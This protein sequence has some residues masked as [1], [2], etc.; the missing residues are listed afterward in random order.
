MRIVKGQLFIIWTLT[1]HSNA[2]VILVAS[3]YLGEYDVDFSHYVPGVYQLQIERENK[4]LKMY[5][6]A[7]N[8]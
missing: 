4:T 5:H 8:R 7:K 6:I 1:P 2:S 3:V